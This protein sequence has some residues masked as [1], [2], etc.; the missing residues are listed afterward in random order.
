MNDYEGHVEKKISLCLTGGAHHVYIRGVVLGSCGRSV[1]S[2]SQLSH[3]V[4]ATLTMSA[5]SRGVEVKCELEF[6]G[7]LVTTSFF[8]QRQGVE[9]L[10]FLSF[11]SRS[12]C[13]MPAGVTLSVFKLV[14]FVSSPGRN[15][16]PALLRRGGEQPAS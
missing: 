9:S 10:Y 14:F 6:G 4:I 12:V 16:Y 3:F 5:L 11:L 8:F 7:K 15:G 1:K 2:T 13:G